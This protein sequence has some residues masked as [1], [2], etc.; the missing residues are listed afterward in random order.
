MDIVHENHYSSKTW[1]D[2]QTTVRPPATNIIKVIKLLKIKIFVFE[3]QGESRSKTGARTT[4]FF[5]RRREDAEHCRTVNQ[6]IDY[7]IKNAKTSREYQI[8]L[9]VTT[10]LCTLHL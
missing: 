8:L 10:E 6:T 2:G 5:V 1:G 9:V 4:D 7:V 3:F